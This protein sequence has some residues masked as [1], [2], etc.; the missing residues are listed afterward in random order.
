MHVKARVRTLR[1]TR[2]WSVQHLADLINATGHQIGRATLATLEIEPRRHV[3]VDELF[4]LAQ[5][6][7][8]TI[9][10]LTGDGALCQTCSDEP[11]PGFACLN[12]GRNGDG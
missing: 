4:A 3:T 10:Q 9:E 7:G 1:K 5:A 8:V 11:P 2:G 6:F 12:C